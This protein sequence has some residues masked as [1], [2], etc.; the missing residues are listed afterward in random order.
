MAKVTNHSGEIVASLLPFVGLG[1]GVY[2]ISKG[3]SALLAK[4]SPTSGEQKTNEISLTILNDE[5]EKPLADP[6][7]KAKWQICRG[8][9][10]A[11][12][13]P[14][15][16]VYGIVV[17]CY[18]KP[19]ANPIARIPKT[20]LDRFCLDVRKEL[21][22]L[23]NIKP[24]Q[25]KIEHR[26]DTY[27]TIKEAFRLELL[28]RSM[29]VGLPENFLDLLFSTIKPEE[30]RELQRFHIVNDFE[31]TLTN[32]FKVSDPNF[33][34][35]DE[36][37]RGLVRE[38]INY[39]DAVTNQDREYLVNRGKDFFSLDD[40]K[41]RQ[42]TEWLDQEQIK[43]PFLRMQ[44]LFDDNLSTILS[45]YCNRKNNQK[46]KSSEI[47]DIITIF[48]STMSLSDKREALQ[49]FSQEY[50]LD[51]HNKLDQGDAQS[52][53]TM[54]S[55]LLNFKEACINNEMS[56]GDRVHIIETTIKLLQE[57]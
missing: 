26:I 3:V 55:A 47:Q 5:K 36:K 31:G 19:L 16:L 52:L 41:Q 42:L 11:L 4:R 53:F 12:W 37:H 45:N 17:W 56:P 48:N 57:L 50:R 24:D 20:P 25:E 18:S 14:G 49:K 28:K 22:E 35:D 34:Y 15:L 9:A 21:E 10:E 40:T 6:I 13:I 30:N 43:E 39:V 44:R 32:L 38:L 54:L 46:L 7:T 2:N 33:V 27:Q 51:N 23:K 8:V 1:I 29:E